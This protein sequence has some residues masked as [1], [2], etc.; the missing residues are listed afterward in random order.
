MCSVWVVGVGSCAIYLEIVGREGVDDLWGDVKA[1]R[2]GQRY[3]AV[4]ILATYRVLHQPV[5]PWTASQHTQ[6]PHSLYVGQNTE[7]LIEL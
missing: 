6:H 1:W 7:Q 2:A 3:V 5:N 4:Q